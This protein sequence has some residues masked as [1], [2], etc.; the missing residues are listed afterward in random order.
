MSASLSVPI[1]VSTKKTGTAPCPGPPLPASPGRLAV[2]TLFQCAAYNR[3]AIASRML[4]TRISSSPSGMVSFSRL[5][6]GIIHFVKPKRF[7]SASLCPSALAARSLP[8]SPT[9]PIATRS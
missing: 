9:L 1:P 2:S 5:R 6:L 3:A 8:V 7:A 4:V